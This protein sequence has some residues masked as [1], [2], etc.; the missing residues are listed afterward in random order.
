MKIKLDSYEIT[1][2]QQVVKHPGEKLSIGVGEVEDYGLVKKLNQ[3]YLITVVGAMVLK[4]HLPVLMN[5]QNMK[6]SLGFPKYYK[7]ITKL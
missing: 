3:G 7:K 4:Q 6:Q 1:A 2:L 5:G